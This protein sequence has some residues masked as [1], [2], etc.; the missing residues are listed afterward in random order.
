M[1]AKASKPPD[2]WLNRERILMIVLA[3]ATTLVAMLVLRLV[4]PFV[5]AITWAVVLAVM[6]APLHEA[7]SRR[8]RWP[9]LAASLAVLVA[10]LGIAAPAIWLLREVV[11]QALVGVELLRTAI[12]RG[13]WQAALDRFP[14]LAPL[15]SWID[16]Q[17]L[18]SELAG[19]AAE[20]VKTLRGF[21]ARTFDVALSTLIMLFLLFYFLR[22]KEEMLTAVKSLV[23]LAPPEADKV[24]ANV[25]RT[26]HAM[27]YGRLAVAIVQGALGGLMFWWLGVPAPLLW[28]GV[29][30]LLSVLPVVGAALVWVPAVLYL[31]WQGDAGKALILLAWGG[32]VVSVVDNLLYPMLVNDKLRL[33][34]V[35]VFIAVLGGLTV[36]GPTGI[37]LGPLVLAIG[38]ALLEIWQRRIAMGEVVSGVDRGRDGHTRDAKV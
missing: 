15:R 14:A 22:D 19:A 7:L 17:A 1:V 8:V 4:A 30:A 32:L 13:E 25:R 23:P 9:W 5:A 26:I 3:L 20:G 35:A 18:S 16:S 27:V 21:L 11:Q 31:A 2:A 29:M 34:T 12:E 28:A 24:L 10:T 36:F 37:V 33:H 6:T 38:M